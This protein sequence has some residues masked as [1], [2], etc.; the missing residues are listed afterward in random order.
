MVAPLSLESTDQ[1]CVPAAYLHARVD[2][3]LVRSFHE[4]VSAWQGISL[5]C[6]AVE[7]AYESMM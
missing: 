3:E 1:R 2:S 4:P 6:E 5:H 7:Q